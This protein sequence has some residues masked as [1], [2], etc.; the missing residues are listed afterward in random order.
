[1]EIQPVLVADTISSNIIL[2]VHRVREDAPAMIVCIEHQA[3]LVKLKMF[4]IHVVSSSIIPI[5]HTRPV[6]NMWGI[7][8]LRNRRGSTVIMIIAMGIIQ[9]Q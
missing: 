4:P 1:M 9:P 3:F 6:L 8:S 2:S 5:V 7:I